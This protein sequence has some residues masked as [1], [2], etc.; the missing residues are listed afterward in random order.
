MSKLTESGCQ[1]ELQRTIRLPIRE[2]WH[3]LLSKAGLEIWLGTSELEKWETG[4]KFKANNGIQGK[5]RVFNPYTHIR[6]SW[7]YPGWKNV[8][9][10]NI[11]TEEREKEGEVII[12]IHQEQLTDKLQEKEMMGYW[13]KVLNDL[14][15]LL[16]K[17]YL[18]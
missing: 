16:K 1:V 9:I 17:L 13:T 12:R 11:R 2:V 14:I 10:L 3:A 8:S 6:L 18:H 5:V 7:Q 15:S 4:I